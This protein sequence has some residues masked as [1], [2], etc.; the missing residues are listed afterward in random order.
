MNP[1]LLQVLLGL[2]LLLNTFVLVGFVY[3]SWIAPPFE[4]EWPPPPRGAP[5]QPGQAGQPGGPRFNPVEMVAHDLD[6]D[7]EQ[8]KVLQGLFDQYAKARRDRLRE[9][10]R[11]REQTAVEMGRTPLDMTRIER[12]V[13]QVSQLRGEQQKETLRTLTQLQPALRDD[14]R[15]RLLRLVV[16]RVTPPPPPPSR[17][18]GG[19][20]PRPPQ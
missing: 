7:A 8:R 14:Q 6:L 15:E 10:Q 16:D 11:V 17:P 9:I 3:R 5:G 4:N 20:P 2:S 19:G 12:L 1:R 18:P 13:D